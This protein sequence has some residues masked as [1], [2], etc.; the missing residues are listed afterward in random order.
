MNSPFVRAFAVCCLVCVPIARAASSGGEN[1]RAAVAAIV[2][3]VRRRGDAAVLYHT[4][5]FD[6]AKLNVRQLR[7]PGLN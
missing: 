6:H 2:A 4:A 1:L 7:V 5:K 3:D